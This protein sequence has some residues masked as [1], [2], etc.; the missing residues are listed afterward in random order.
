[1]SVSELDRRREVVGIYRRVSTIIWQRLSPTFG[2]RTINA[3][4]RNV[5]A[6]NS[7]RHP[8]ISALKVTD[9][10]LEWHEL[11]MVLEQISLRDLRAMLDDFID[12]FFEALSSLIGKLVVGK[13][14]KEAEAAAR[15]GGKR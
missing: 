9:N 13:I 3:I 7:K 15:K 10:G 2:G 1:M 6:R 11:E 5:I 12:E 14:F 8:H 4:A